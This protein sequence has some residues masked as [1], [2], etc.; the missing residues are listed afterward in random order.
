M[1]LANFL[2]GQGGCTLRTRKTNRV[3]KRER[4]SIWQGMEGRDAGG[5][6]GYD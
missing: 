5:D 2:C 4:K 6:I 3:G 1:H